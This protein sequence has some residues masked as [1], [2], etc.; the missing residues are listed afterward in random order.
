METTTAKGADAAISPATPATILGM[1]TAAFTTLHVAISLAGIASGIVVVVCM[2]TSTELDFWTGVF[3]ATTVLTSATGFLFHA[4]KV[5]PSH[6]VGVLSLV[7]LAAAI[8]ALYAFGLAGAWRTVYVITAVTSLYLNVFVLV[9]QSFL[10]VPAL[11]ALAPKGSEP[12]FAIAQGIV[13]ILFV[14]LGV[15]AVRR[16]HPE[17]NQGPALGERVT[18]PAETSQAKRR[19]VSTGH[20]RPWV[21]RFDED[22]ETLLELAPVLGQVEPSAMQRVLGRDDRIPRLA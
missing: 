17:Q 14:A 6:I 4:E 9:V 15:L 2:L 8:L 22:A 12:P 19:P 21:V 1:S 3:L 20:S 10:K 18:P 13:L 7:L 11:H 16:F 5:L